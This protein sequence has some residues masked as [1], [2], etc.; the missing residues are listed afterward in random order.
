MLKLGVFEGKYMNDCHAEFPADWFTHAKTSK[1]PDIN[2]NCFKIKSRQPLYVWRQKGWIIPPIRAV[3]FMVLPLLHGPP[4]ARRGCKA[5]QT[6]AGV[7]AARGAGDA[8]LQTRGRCLSS[9]PTPGAAAM[10]L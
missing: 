4:F 6:L 2:L 9:A 1:T 8:K 10:G 3:G 5:N 7:Q